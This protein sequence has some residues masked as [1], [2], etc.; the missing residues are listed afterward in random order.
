MRSITN[1]FYITTPDATSFQ[2]SRGEIENTIVLAMQWAM[3]N[4]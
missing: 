1:N 2:R 3:R 4:V